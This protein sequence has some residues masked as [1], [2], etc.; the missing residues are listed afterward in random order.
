LIDQDSGFFLDFGFLNGGF[1]QGLNR[2]FSSDVGFWFFFG[3]WIESLV[4]HT[5]QYKHTIQLQAVQENNCSISTLLI[6]RLF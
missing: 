3:H 1:F 2:G 5:Q 4:D 6:L